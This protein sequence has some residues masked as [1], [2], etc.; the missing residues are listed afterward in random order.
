MSNG[1]YRILNPQNEKMLGYLPGSE[2]RRGLK[3][4]L[5]ELREAAVE[6]PMIIGGREVRSRRIGRCIIP[7]D[8]ARVLATYHM[9]G[10]AE[11]RMAVQAALDAGRAWAETP[12]DHRLAVFLRAAE[13]ISGP[14]R[15]TLNAATM[16]GQ[17]KTVYEAEADA[18]CELTD[19]FRFNSYF[20]RQIL[21]EQP[22]SV[23]GILNRM[24]YR[25][26]E[27]FVFA[28]T[29]FNFTAIGGNLP[30]A[31]AVSGNTVVWKPASTAVLSN[32]YVMK[33]LEA[34]GLPDGV[35]NFIPGPGSEVGPA[36]LAHPMLAGVHFTGS[37]AVFQEM[38]RTVAGNLDGYNGYPRLV[39]ETG[40]KDFAFV[41]PSAEVDALIPALV[42]GAFSYQ[43]QKCSATSR[44]YLPE[45]LWPGVRPRLLEAVAGIRMG[46]PADFTHYMGA[47]I[48]RPAFEKIY[49]CLRFVRESDKAE[50]VAG[51]ECDDAGGFFI[52]P[53][54]I[55]TQDPGFRT[56]REE[57]FGP[58]LTVFVYPDGDLEKALG[59]CAATSRYALT[60][61][62]F[63]RDRAA[64]VAMERRLRHSAGN[65]YINDKTTGALVGCQPFGG[66]RMSGT[67]DKAGSRLNL[68]RWLSPRAIKENFNP[69]RDY[70]FGL[71]REA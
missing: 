68:L 35:I 44:V 15:H 27:G 60:G 3:A 58:V 34:A 31:P 20:L 24:E 53:T 49:G 46:D 25:P 70:R 71:M 48:D 66:S 64:I 61:A 43:G 57:I 18:A 6:I 54:V 12:W 17:S 33:V 10:E 5:A 28:A 13:L 62:V 56:M 7:H 67:N 63:A 26:L 2:E 21:E 59:L 1:V 42:A 69:P 22:E 23:Q 65:L 4:R 36:V 41:H 47:V 52:R 8:H 9:A 38:W 29:P 40:G 32:Y 11:V 45:S 16:L 50:I 55:V 51:G 37:T 14:W 39:G 30:G 19:F